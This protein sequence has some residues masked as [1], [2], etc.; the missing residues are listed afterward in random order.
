M[1]G[2]IK[3]E[4]DITGQKF[5][6]LT[7]VKRDG[8]TS[9]GHSAWI[10]KCE[11]GNLTRTRK[12]Q[13]TNGKIKSCGCFMRETSRNLCISRSTHGMYGTRIYKEWDSMKYRCNPK[14]IRNRKNYYDRGIRVCAEWQ[15]DFMNF[16]SWAMAN[17][18]RD[19]LTLDRINVN[20]IY[21]PSNCRWVPMREQYRNRTDN[22]YV[23]ING[24]VK[25]LA[26]WAYEN[27][28]GRTTICDRY[29]RGD[30]GKDLIR[31]IWSRSKW[32]WKEGVIK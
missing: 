15:H 20:G 14:N 30:R 31:P 18:Y 12:D 21:E 26:D 28:L 7:A 17:G 3:T 29:K 13:V 19:D 4:K 2:V 24:E 27:G 9:D 6:R 11:C 16:Y 10:F 1:K 5:N 23:E 22:T 25:I 8:L 32:G